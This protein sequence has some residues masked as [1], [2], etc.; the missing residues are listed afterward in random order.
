MK[1]EIIFA[2]SVGVA[3]KE[4]SKFN[5]LYNSGPS[6]SANFTSTSEIDIKSF[7]KISENPGIFINIKRNQ[8]LF[9]SFKLS[10]L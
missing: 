3:V 6:L 10:F 7:N 5:I 9:N 1:Y 2:K 4:E 8:W